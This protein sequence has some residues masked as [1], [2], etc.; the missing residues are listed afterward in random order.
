MPRYW[1][2]RKRKTHKYYYKLKVTRVEE[3]P[4]LGNFTVR[5]STNQ[6]LFCQP[7]DEVECLAGFYT[8]RKADS[9][10]RKTPDWQKER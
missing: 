9:I 4:Q 1:R 8:L 10:L 6:A 3:V 2:G 7:G 5:F